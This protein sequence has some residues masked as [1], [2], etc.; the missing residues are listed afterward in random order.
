M[1][2]TPMPDLRPAVTNRRTVVVS[3]SSDGYTFFSDGKTSGPTRVDTRV[4]L[5]AVE[6]W[7]IWNTS[8]E[9]HPFHIYIG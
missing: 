6:E 5:G 9:W 2:L 4:R 3:E 1:S 8:G 7:T